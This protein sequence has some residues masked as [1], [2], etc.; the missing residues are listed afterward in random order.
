MSGQHTQNSLLRAYRYLRH[1][2]GG[3]ALISGCICHVAPYFKSVKPRLLKLEANYCLAVISKRHAL[4]NHIGTVHVIA[5]CNGLEFAMGSMVTASLPAHLRW[6]PKGMQVNYIG[7][8]D[9]DVRL[10][11]SV[12]PQAW[13]TGDVQVEVIALGEDDKVVVSGYITI[14]VTEKPLH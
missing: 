3:R 14:W 8:A 12:A 6:I 4:Q 5:I 1:L 9:S 13:Q 10:I 2:P 7:K 11:A